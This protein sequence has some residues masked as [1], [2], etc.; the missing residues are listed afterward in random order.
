MTRHVTLA[1]GI[2]SFLSVL[3]VAG[4]LSG[5]GSDGQSQVAGFRVAA[6]MPEEDDRLDSLDS[7]L[8]VTFSADVDP[9]TVNA[10]S[11]RV[12]SWSG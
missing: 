2:C 6:V 3:L 5:S 7:P 9:S 12:M 4:C 1:T 8:E 10:Q 11:L